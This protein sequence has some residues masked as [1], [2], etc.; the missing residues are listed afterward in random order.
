MIVGKCPYCDGNVIAKA[1]TIQGKSITLYTCEHAI[2]ER[3]LNN[4]YVFSAESTCRFRVY[5]NA[6]LRWNKRSFGVNEMK[7]LLRDGQ[8]V[9]R[10]HG[11]KG[12]KEYFKYA[13]PDPQY[14]VSILWDQE[15]DEK[16][17][18]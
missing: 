5:S 13:L 18:M 7:T 8:V 12:S 6:F 11:K 17:Y 9:V 4:D 3:D 1:F 10:L 2:K 16:P 14:G 15:V